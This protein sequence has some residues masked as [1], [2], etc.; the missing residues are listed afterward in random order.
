MINPLGIKTADNPYSYCLRIGNG[1]LTNR[2]WS[3]GSFSWGVTIEFEG[4]GGLYLRKDEAVFLK[5]E[6]DR[7]LGINC[8]IESRSSSISAHE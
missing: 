6:I 7:Q 3:N 5:E 4:K 2:H 1:Y 8:I